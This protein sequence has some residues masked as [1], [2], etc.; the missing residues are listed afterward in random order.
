[1]KYASIL[2][3][4][5]DSHLSNENQKPNSLYIN[6]CNRLTCLKVVISFYFSTFTCWYVQ[7]FVHACS[8]N[9]YNASMPQNNNNSAIMSAA[10]NGGGGGEG[11]LITNSSSSS[12]TFGGN[13][14]QPNW[15]QCRPVWIDKAMQDIIKVPHTFIVHTYKTPT[16]CQFCRKL[17]K[18]IYKQGYQCKG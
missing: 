11:P 2:S 1:M 16:I 8:G 9:M 13:Q 6:I 5:F 4:I 12:T 15:Y 7:R 14:Q 3:E 18:G 10:W 17:L